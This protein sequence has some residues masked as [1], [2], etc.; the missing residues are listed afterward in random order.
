M[1]NG[2]ENISKPIT[3][4]DVKRVLDKIR[5]LDC[6]MEEFLEFERKFPNLTAMDYRKSKKQCTKSCWIL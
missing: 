2:I 1:M 4:Q 6:Q 5:L 3:Y